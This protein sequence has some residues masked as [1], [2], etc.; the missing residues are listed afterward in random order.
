MCQVH[1]GTPRESVKAHAS[2]HMCP[3]AGVK[4]KLHPGCVVKSL[5]LPLRGLLELFHFYQPKLKAQ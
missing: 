2:H 1:E 3:F 5:V 4:E